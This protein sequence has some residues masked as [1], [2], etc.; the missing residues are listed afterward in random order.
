MPVA[1]SLPKRVLGLS[2]RVLGLTSFVVLPVPVCSPSTTR[3]SSSYSESSSR[4]DPDKRIIVNHA[5]IEGLLL[6]LC[7]RGTG[8]KGVKE[9]MHMAV[10]QVV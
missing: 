8:V 5:L 6:W 7:V 4:V 1:R 10:R 9:L 2:S 3:L